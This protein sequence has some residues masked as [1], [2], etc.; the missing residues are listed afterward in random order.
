[1]MAKLS[2]SKRTVTALTAFSIILTLL[3]LFYATN[4][5]SNGLQ[6]AGG[7]AKTIESNATSLQQPQLPIKCIEN[8]ADRNQI[9]LTKQAWNQ[10]LDAGATPEYYLSIVIVTRMDDYAGNQH[11]RFQNFID[12]AYLLAEH[13]EQKIE[14]LIIEWN[15]PEHKRRILDAFR[16]RR[17]KYLNYR[18]ITVSNKIHNILPNKGNAPL[19]EFEGKNV[20]IR[21]ARGE[22]VVCTNQDDIWSHNFINAVKSRVFEKD[23]I[24]VQYQSAHNM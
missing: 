19:H 21:F 16:F 12:S 4:R 9:K 15:P 2:V 23:T 13:S 14:L 18:I 5:N 7:Y 24:Y 11:H 17:S 1:M 8:T 20:G 22:F 3:C 10:C 6:S